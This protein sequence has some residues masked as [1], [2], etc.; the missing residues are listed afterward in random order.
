MRLAFENLADSVEGWPSPL[1]MG[2][3]QTVEG[4]KRTKGKRRRNSLL[5]PASLLELGH[6]ISSSPAFEL[7]FTTDVPL[8]LMVLDLD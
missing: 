5:F 6:L 1:R 8:F 3:I 7:G 4:L 2:V